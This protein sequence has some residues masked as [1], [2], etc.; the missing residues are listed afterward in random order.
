MTRASFCQYKPRRGYKC[1]HSFPPWEV[2]MKRKPRG[3]MKG[4]DYYNYYD[5]TE[6]NLFSS[7][8]GEVT[9]QNRFSPLVGLS[10]DVIY[11]YDS[12]EDLPLQYSNRHD[13]YPAQN[14]RIPRRVCFRDQKD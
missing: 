8:G 10:V 3:V 11:D 1:I 2:P 9:T 6:G 5:P 13:H 7:R 12:D 4:R 14:K